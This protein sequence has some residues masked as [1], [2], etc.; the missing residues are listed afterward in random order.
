M[1]NKEEIEFRIKNTAKEKLGNLDE[2]LPVY[3]ENNDCIPYITIEGDYYVLQTKCL[4]IM[5]YLDRENY[6]EMTYEY[7]LY[8]KTKEIDEL[9][10]II[11]KNIIITISNRTRD[12]RCSN[13][14]EEF[15]NKRQL[16]LMSSLNNEWEKRLEI[17]NKN[18]QI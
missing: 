18:E 14:S 15:K 8:C 16:F 10:Y 5:Y 13:D 6:P 12:G 2:L 1:L 7:H 3:R 9:L 11:F 17:E 4:D